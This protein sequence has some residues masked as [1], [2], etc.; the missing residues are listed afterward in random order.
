M[1]QIS[2]TRPNARRC[3]T[4]GSQPAEEALVKIRA[5]CFSLVWRS[6]G[7]KVALREHRHTKSMREKVEEL[8]AVHLIT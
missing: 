2:K 1:E 8:L 6:L 7:V 4:Y 3:P 5:S